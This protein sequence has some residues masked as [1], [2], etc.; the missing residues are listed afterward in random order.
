MEFDI[1][2]ILQDIENAIQD[3]I[4]TANLMLSDLQTD[5]DVVISEFYN[6]FP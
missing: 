2:E 1:I 4:D 3:I 5:A 6:D